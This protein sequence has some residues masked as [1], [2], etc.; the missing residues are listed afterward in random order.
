MPQIELLTSL[1]LSDLYAKADQLKGKA[2][3]P[4]A[5]VEAF[6]EY[7]VQGHEY[8]LNKE[9]SAY[10]LSAWKPEIYGNLAVKAKYYEARS[11]YYLT[12]LGY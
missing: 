12:L 10:D 5:D 2:G 8:W 11:C 1:E 3:R 7:L 4:P 6:G 9:I